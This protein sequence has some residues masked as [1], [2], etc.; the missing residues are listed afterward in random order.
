MKCLREIQGAS[1]R[2]YTGVAGTD[3]CDLQSPSCCGTCFLFD[4]RSYFSLPCWRSSAAGLPSFLPIRQA[5]S[6][7]LAFALA[8]APTWMLSSALCL[9]GSFLNLQSFNI[10]ITQCQRPSPTVWFKYPPTPHILQLQSFI[11]FLLTFPPSLPSSFFPSLANFCPLL[12]FYSP[13]A[14]GGSQ[15]RSPIGAVAISLRHNH[16]NAESKPQL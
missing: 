1:S 4:L 14:C 2:R 16:S 12:S 7:P 11:F 10:D 8:V 3:P 9:P 15:A 13:A 6:Y 5:L